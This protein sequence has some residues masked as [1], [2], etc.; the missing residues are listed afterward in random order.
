ME[1]LQDEIS[2]GLAQLRSYE[3]VPFLQDMS[4]WDIYE[5]RIQTLYVTLSLYL[6]YKYFIT[7]ISRK[8][9]NFDSKDRARRHFDVMD[10]IWK[11]VRDRKLG[12]V[13][14]EENIIRQ[15]ER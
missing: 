12:N 5:S 13:S 8:I 15:A 14:E 9:N 4:S 7:I 6:N 1:D 3:H 11:Q 2:N 10:K